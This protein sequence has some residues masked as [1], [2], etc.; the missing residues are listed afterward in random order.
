MS[1]RVLGIKEVAEIFEWRGKSSQL[2]PG[3]S[4]RRGKSPKRERIVPKIFEEV[5]YFFQ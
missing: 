2:V 1:Q 3:F 5:K 4:S